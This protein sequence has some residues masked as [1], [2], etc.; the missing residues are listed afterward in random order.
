MA[1]SPQL[2]AAVAKVVK[3]PEETVRVA[4]RR[5]H[6]A[7]LIEVTG[8]GRGG[9]HMTARDAA[10]LLLAMS[11]GTMLKDSPTTIQ[12]YW[13]LPL[14]PTDPHR[15]DVL[16][17]PPGKRPGLTPRYFARMFTKKITPVDTLGVV[18]STIIERACAGMLFPRPDRGDFAKPPEPHIPVPA[19]VP[20]SRLQVKIYAP[21]RAASIHL[22]MNLQ[23]QSEMLFG[24][25]ATLGEEAFPGEDRLA[26]VD[27]VEIRQFSELAILAIGESLR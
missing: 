7:G 1:K 10:M 18:L 11:M 17:F 2:V 8:R 14:L 25:R 4:L 15:F 19:E 24:E 21:W 27:Y 23:W 22:R 3:K 5:L 6:E 12:D 20:N 26:N 13:N 16:G 9:K